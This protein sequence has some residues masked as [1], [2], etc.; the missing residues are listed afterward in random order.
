MEFRSD[1]HLCTTCP[2]LLIRKVNVLEEGSNSTYP[3]VSSPV[4][5]ITP[6]GWVTPLMLRTSVGDH[7]RISTA[8]ARGSC[9]GS[10]LHETAPHSNSTDSS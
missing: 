5:A 10:C 7:S 1:S 2:S 4:S 6:R 3:G 9:L 8:S